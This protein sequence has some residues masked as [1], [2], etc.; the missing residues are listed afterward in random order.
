M[1][2]RITAG[3]LGLLLVILPLNARA[4]GED[5]RISGVESE[6]QGLETVVQGTKSAAEKARLDIKLQR[7][8]DELS[9]L[10]QR[11]ELEAKAKALAD[12][13]NASPLEA[14]REK[15]RLVDASEE[16]ARK[17]IQALSLRRRASASERD[18][19]TA[20]LDTLR[21]AKAAKPDPASDALLAETEE[22]L[23][24]HNEELRAL[25]LQ[26]EAAELE[27]ELSQDADRIRET[28]KNLNI[29]SRPNIKSIIDEREALTVSARH[30]AAVRARVDEQLQS[31]QMSKEVLA[32][33]QMKLSKFDEELAL[34]EK[35]TSFFSSN[36]R[37]ER[38][39]A[40][41]RA[42]KRAAQERLPFLVD[43]LEALKHANQLITL[44]AELVSTEHTLRASR[45]E[46]ML[47]TYLN[48]LRWPAWG[49]CSVFLIY[50]FTHFGVLPLLCR[51]E[52]RPIARRLARYAAVAAS[53]CVVIGF[54][55]DDLS[56]MA[57]TMGVVSAALVISLQD[58]CASAFAWFVIMLGG[59]FRAGDRLEVDGMRGDVIDIDLLRTTLSEVNGWLGSDLPT[60]R[61][62]V[63]PNNFIFR[64]KVL[65]YSHQ[66][67]YIWGSISL[68][69]TFGTSVPKASE[70][71]LAVLTAETEE[72]FA[73]ARKA[74]EAFK[75]RYGNDNSLY[76]PRVQAH[77]ADSGVTLTLFFVSH[78]LQFSANRSRINAALLTALAKRPDIQL[79]FN[80]LQVLHGKDS[81]PI[82][83]ESSAAS[84]LNP[85]TLPSM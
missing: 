12:D 79:A 6:I 61:V 34:L 72:D 18:A 8:R 38:L 10:R 36:P 4:S 67:P 53:L 7:L 45:A 60:G 82:P 11:R 68:T 43:Q 62:V 42:Q 48:R 32:L 30:E 9:I 78:Y 16:E 35:Q 20:Q 77:I 47:T 21:A 26:R 3:L 50:L 83:A 49:L 57:A 71:F 66:H 40:I 2:P 76:E 37:V 84:A 69:V 25:S 33:A 5:E 81:P 28:L 31:L 63:I 80:T 19:L 41:Q 17:R 24:T 73:A 85:I 51:R 14:L 52:T 22:R 70:L 46:G 55:F 59:K 58:A 64:S 75:D 13:R 23:Y 27:I 54:L 29:A 65:N 1:P 56:M 44:Q 74:G 39:L 15:L